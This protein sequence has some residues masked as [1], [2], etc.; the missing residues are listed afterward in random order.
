VVTVDLIT[1]LPKSAGYDSIWVAVDRVSKRIHIAPTTKEIDSVGNAR[2][3]RDHIW[4]HHGLPD[5]IIS[6][7]GPQFVQSFT[8]EL[9]RLLG[10]ETRSS[11]SFHPQTDG[12]TE[13]VNMEI[14]Q[15]LRMFTNQRQSDWADWLPLAE[16][17][18]N[19][20]VH[21]STRATPFE[22]D[23]GRHPRMGVEPRRTSRV[24]AVNEFT[25][26][27]AKTLEETRSALRMAAEDMARYYDA[28]RE[29]AETFVSGD[30]VWLDGR[31]IKTTRPTK[32]L[33]DRWFGPFKVEKPVSRNAYKLK[34]TKAFAQLYPVF[35]VSLLRRCHPDQITERPQPSRPDPELVGDHLEYE[36]DKVLDSKL[37]RSHLHYLV[38]FK[39]YGPEENLWL[40]EENITAPEA[41]ADFRR[42]NPSAPRRISA[43][44]MKELMFR[45]YENLT[46]PSTPVAPINTIT[47]RATKS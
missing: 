34:L 38:S 14:E 36:I 30:K 39:G 28:H 22:L 1:G 3:F 20:R 31:N 25:Q 42:L 11:T 41:I 10:I 35:H 16:F 46:T 13:R 26:R 33:D 18:Y 6:D 21:S 2:L 23:T 7:R 5:Q 12:Q 8:Q 29:E 27:M 44:V 24:E 47:R 9:N 4:R 37:V 17:A 15:Y 32:K 45:K 40:P 43:N 19:N